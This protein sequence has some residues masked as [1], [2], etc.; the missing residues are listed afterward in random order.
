MINENDHKNIVQIHVERARPAQLHAATG[1]CSGISHT[2]CAPRGKGQPVMRQY[3]HISSLELPP[4]P[5]HPPDPS[6]TQPSGSE[7][8]CKSGSSPCPP[9]CNAGRREAV[10]A[11]L[12][13]R[14]FSRGKRATAR[15]DP[16][17]YVPVTGMAKPMTMTTPHP[18]ANG[19]M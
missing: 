15:G 1:R 6:G 16:R 17:D 12:L 4:W 7:R 9:L 10:S 3:N 5:S 8:A 2:L 11:R 19:R 13:A 14:D 18:M